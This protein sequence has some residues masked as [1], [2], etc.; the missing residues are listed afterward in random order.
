MGSTKGRNASKFKYLHWYNWKGPVIMKCAFLNVNKQ[1]SLYKHMRRKLICHCKYLTL[2]LNQ[3]MAYSFKK[4]VTFSL[5]SHIIIVSLIAYQVILML[6]SWTFL[7]LF[8][9]QCVLHNMMRFEFNTSAKQ[10]TYPTLV[11]LRQASFC[12]FCNL[13][14]NNTFNTIVCNSRHSNG[15]C[16]TRTWHFTNLKNLSSPY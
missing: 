10:K 15:D 3:S 5:P 1:Y 9:F 16:K 12:G 13:K 11:G 7:T 8:L 14:S 4:R 2:W 6:L